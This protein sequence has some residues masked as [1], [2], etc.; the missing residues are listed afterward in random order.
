MKLTSFHNV[1]KH[2]VFTCR[3]PSSCHLHSVEEC[4][5]GLNKII[6]ILALVPN[7]QFITVTA[8]I[9]ENKSLKLSQHPKY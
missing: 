6:A 8:T 2:I 4:T 5:P 3:D 9:S 1:L 7:S